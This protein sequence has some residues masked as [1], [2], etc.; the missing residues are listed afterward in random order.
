MFK[1]LLSDREV[2]E[3]KYHKLDEEYDFFNRMA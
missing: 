2:I 3:N 1:T